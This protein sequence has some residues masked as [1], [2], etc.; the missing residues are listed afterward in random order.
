MPR[1]KT[2]R[3]VEQSRG[4]TRTDVAFCGRASRPTLRSIAVVREHNWMTS[5]P[6]YAG[7]N[8]FE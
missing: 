1:K 2:I 3:C 7:V 5:S 4:A 8:S 6:G